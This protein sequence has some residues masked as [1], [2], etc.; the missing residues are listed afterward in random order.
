MNNIVLFGLLFS[1]MIIL[2]I[3]FNYSLILYG[4]KILSFSNLIYKIQGSNL[5]INYLSAF[6]SYIFLTFALYFFIIKDNKSSFRKK[7][8]NAFILGLTIYGV[9]EAT[10]LALFKNWSP[11]IV[12]SDTLWGATLMLLT[13]YIFYKLFK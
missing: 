3:I 8:V 12:L 6:L 11:Y 2:D 7:L 4:P 5:K 1:I 13:T 9:F 10:N